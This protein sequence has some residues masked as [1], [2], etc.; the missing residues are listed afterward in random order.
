MPTFRN[1]A[2]VNDQTHIPIW[3]T[4]SKKILADNSY[5]TLEE[6]RREEEGTGRSGYFY[7]LDAPEWANIIAITEQDDVILIEQF[8]QGTERIELELPSGMVDA[9]ETPAD[10]ALRELLEETGYEKSERS[11]FKKIGEV[12][13]NPAFMRNRCHTYLLTHARLTGAVRFDENETIRLRLVRRS[14]IEQ[15][16]RSGEIRHALIVAAVYWMK[17]AGS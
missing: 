2:F 1:F 10:A 6:H 3:R 5:L 4:T 9:A 12:S 7:I 11:E 15:R 14:E 16:V 13:P 8:R 17:L